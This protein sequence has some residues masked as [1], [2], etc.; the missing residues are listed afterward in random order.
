MLQEDLRKRRRKSRR[1]RRRKRERKR[2]KITTYM[3]HESRFEPKAEDG[4]SGLSDGGA[5]GRGERG[6]PGRD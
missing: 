5:G 3:Y 1:K 2:E 4:G 6:Q